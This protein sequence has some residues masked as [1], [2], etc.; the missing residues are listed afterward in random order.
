[1]QS[2]DTAV[3]TGAFSYTGSAVARSLLARGLQG[4]TLTNRNLPVS[5]P[6]APIEAHPL[7]FDDPR[8]L[9][10]AMRGA[11]ILSTPTG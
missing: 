3:V 1:M 6:G 9:V 4:P 8:A 10:E 5:D 7:Q 11:R 2:N